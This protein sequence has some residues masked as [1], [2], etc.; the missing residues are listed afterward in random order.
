[1]A[2]KKTTRKPATKLEQLKATLKAHPEPLPNPASFYG[3]VEPQHPTRR[4]LINAL[5]AIRYNTS[6][7]AK[8]NG[9]SQAAQYVVEH[10]TYLFKEGK[11]VQALALRE[12]GN[13]IEERATR[14]MIQAGVP[15]DHSPLIEEAFAILTDAQ[16]DQL[17]N[18]Y[19]AK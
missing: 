12:I 1:M 14:Q 6:E 15:S 8:A 4:A 3:S 2:I 7:H 9:A 10:A 19:A 18:S 17:A 16:L 11:D 13:T 5:H